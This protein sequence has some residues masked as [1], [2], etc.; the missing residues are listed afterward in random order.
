[1]VI[2]DVGIR[3]NIINNEVNCI[4]NFDL[5]FFSTKILK[6]LFKD[7]NINK[8]IKK[9]FIEIRKDTSSTSPKFN[10]KPDKERN[11]IKLIKKEIKKINRN[12]KFSKF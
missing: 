4:L 5:S 1:M 8:I 6:I 2:N 12:N 10:K 9:K 3:L 7:I 11:I